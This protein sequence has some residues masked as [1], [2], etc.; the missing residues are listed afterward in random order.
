M[1]TWRVELT[2][3][4]RSLA[5]I[6]IQRGIFQGD[7]LSPLL[8]II[9]MMPLGHIL[10]KCTD[11][12]KL[13]RSQEKMTLNYLQKMKKDL[14]TLIHAVRIYRQD[15]G[16]EFIKMWHSSHE[17][18]QTTYDWRMKLL[19]RDKIRTL[20]E[21]EI[22]KYLGI[23]EADTIKQYLRR[24]RKL[25]ET[26]LSSRNLMK[27]INTWAVPLVRYSGPFLNRT[28][29]ELKQMNQNTRKLMTMHKALDPRDDVDR[30]Y[31][32]RNEWGRGLASIEDSVDA[33]IDDIAKHER[34]LFTFI[35][36]NTDNTIDDRMT[37]TRKQKWEEKQLY[38]RFKRPI[39]NISHQKTW[40]SLRKENLMRE[41]ESLLIAAQDCAI[42]T[43]HI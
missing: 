19:N 37:I 11:G 22:Y 29:H 6:K 43:N 3:G 20:G 9:A 17:K 28:R 12:Y 14:E 27:G 30:L 35:R 10:R 13:S 34:G 16:V 4:G 7:A 41:T 31:V 40:T 39:K 8:F 32:S 26:Q 23:L 18:W 42:R 38:G 25:L 33:S 15:I 21:N 5:E 2:A 36:N 1:N 24:T